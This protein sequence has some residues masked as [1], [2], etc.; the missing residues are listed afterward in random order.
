[1][2]AAELT[3]PRTPAPPAVW[4]LNW[5]RWSQQERVPRG[6][7]SAAGQAAVGAERARPACVRGPS[8]EGSCR[9]SHRSG[10]GPPRGA[11]APAPQGSKVRPAPSQPHSAR[12]PIP[13]SEFRPGKCLPVATIHISR[14]R[15]P[16]HFPT[17]GASN[18]LWEGGLPWRGGFGGPFK[19]HLLQNAR[20][21]LLR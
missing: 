21:H 8:S 9:G 13:S 15:V 3:S 7:L 2:P 17:K 10:A 20:Q 12:A 16:Y 19:S 11:R 6:P 18:P 5:L 4:A 14:S 1:M